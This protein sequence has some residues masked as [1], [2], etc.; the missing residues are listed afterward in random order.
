VLDHKTASD[1]RERLGLRPL[2]NVSGTMTALGASIMVPEAIQAMVDIGPQFVEID[3]LQRKASAV[4]GTACRAEAGF[5]T[6]SCASGIS[7]AVAGCVTGDQLL[8]IE[9]LPDTGDLKS[10][11][12]IQ[13]GH[14]VSYGAPVVQGIALTGGTVIPVGTVSKTAP[15]HLETI[16]RTQDGGGG[17]CRVASHRSIW[18]DSAF[19]FCRNLSRAGHPRHR[20]RGFRI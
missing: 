6:A 4:I 1:I 16:D 14:M 12:L 15:H 9:R 18:D 17:L 10:E 11:V 20:R 7:L 5:I 8:A 13:M 19:P 3:D 2:I